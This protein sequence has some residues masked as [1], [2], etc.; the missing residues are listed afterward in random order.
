MVGVDIPLH[1]KTIGYN[2]FV[3]KNIDECCLIGELIC[4][5][6]ILHMKR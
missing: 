2:E 6:L 3:L 4:Y 5:R 1:R